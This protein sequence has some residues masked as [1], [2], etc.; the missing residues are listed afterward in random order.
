M[1]PITLT[2]FGQTVRKIIVIISALQQIGSQAIRQLQ[3]QQKQ[4]LEEEKKNRQIQT[5]LRNWA[6]KIGRKVIAI[7]LPPCGPISL[8]SLHICLVINA[9]ILYCILLAANGG[10]KRQAVGGR[11][12]SQPIQINHYFSLAT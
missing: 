3:Q 8:Q 7:S 1:A 11:R 4:Q 5:R 2:R 9:K 10:G 12:L 6:Q